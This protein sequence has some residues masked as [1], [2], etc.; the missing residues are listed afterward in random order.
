MTEDPN[1]PDETSHPKIDWPTIRARYEKG[2][3]AVKAIAA[4]I[5]MH[6]TALV[7]KAKAD[8][9]LLRK[10]VKTKSLS[11]QATLKRLKDLL[12]TRLVKL[13]SEIA[14]IGDDISALSTDKDYR[15]LNTLVRTL[16]KV[17]EL[18]RNERKPRPKP[19]DFKHVDDAERGALAGKIER[20]QQEWRGGETGASAG[21]GGGEGA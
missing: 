4:D 3:E 19:D 21:P 1:P 9:W 18:E 6:W 15:N 20:L 10:K 14:A 12:N 13:E 5:S 8:G 17:L 16:D 7:Q 2:E 11:T